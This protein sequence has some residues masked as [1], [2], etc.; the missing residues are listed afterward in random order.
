MTGSFHKLPR[1]TQNPR[2]GQRSHWVHV[3][4]PPVGEQISVLG[5]PTP[6]PYLE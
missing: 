4:D 3:G 6:T 2:T 1:N 5:S